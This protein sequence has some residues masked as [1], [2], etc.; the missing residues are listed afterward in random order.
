M[1]ASESLRAENTWSKLTAALGHCC[2]RVRLSGD[3]QG[4]N[5]LHFTSPSLIS[6]HGEALV[7]GDD[8][9]A[10]EVRKASLLLCL[11]STEKRLR[12]SCRTCFL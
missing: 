7:H 4:Q 12:R 5:I 8:V 2:I 1:W 9:S 10:G 6:T 3:I 11:Y